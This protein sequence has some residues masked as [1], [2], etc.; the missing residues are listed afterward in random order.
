MI[1]WYECLFPKVLGRCLSYLARNCWMFDFSLYF[2]F[3]HLF[4]TQFSLFPL[5]LFPLFLFPF[6]PSSIST[7][8]SII[9]KKLLQNHKAM[10]CFTSEWPLSSNLFPF[11]ELEFSIADIKNYLSR[12][13]IHLLHF[14]DD[15][16]T[17]KGHWKFFKCWW[18]FFFF[19]FSFD[20]FSSFLL[21]FFISRS[22]LSFAFNV[23]ALI[24]ILFCFFFQGG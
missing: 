18:A 23:A 14:V 13:R 2:H 24:E 15:A 22:L 10:E 17:T 1:W 3:L 19:F 16:P 8:I 7:P 21:F 20:S 6:L 4:L 12:G 11:D 5:F 9:C